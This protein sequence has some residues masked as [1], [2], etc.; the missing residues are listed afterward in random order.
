MTEDMRIAIKAIN[1]WMYFGW[2]FSSKLHKWESV[3]GVIK[4]MV[5]PTFLVE[6]KWECNLDH[7][8]EKWSLITKH[9]D[10]NSYMARFYA[11]LGI[12]N[13]ILLLEWVM[14]HYNDEI[15]IL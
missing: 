15:K 8:V 12:G 4:E 11:E 6:V 5:L 2:N 14:Q 1:K 13:R 7:M 3:N 10:P 9:Y